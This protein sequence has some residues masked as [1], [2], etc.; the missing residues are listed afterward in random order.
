MAVM[1]RDS[2]LYSGEKTKAGVAL[3][4]FN[5]NGKDDIVVGTDNDNIYL[6]YDDGSSA[7]GFPYT[8]E[9]KIQAPPSIQEINGEKVIFSG[10]M[11]IVSML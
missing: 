3:A 2:H 4:D 7:P 5:G 6:I 11:I 1:W 9:D 8:T 10:V